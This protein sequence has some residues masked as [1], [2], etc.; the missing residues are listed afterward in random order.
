MKTCHLFSTII[1]SVVLNWA[2]LNAQKIDSMP[3]VCLNHVLI[4]LD[5]ATYQN[6]FNSS[7]LSDTV[8]NC[9]AHTVKTV[10][11]EW[12]GKYLFGEEGY[13]ELFSTKGGN[14]TPLGSFGF[15]FF[16]FRTG[17]I[18][19][20][21]DEWQ[22]QTTN[23]IWTDT[24]IY[25]DKGIKKSWFYSIGLAPEDSSKFLPVWLMENTPEHM[26]DAGFNDSELKE[27]ISWGTYSRKRREIESFPKL[28]KGITS[29]NITVGSDEFDFLKKTIT[30]FGLH[31]INK[32]FSNPYVCI[33]C[34]VSPEPIWRINTVT[35][36]LKEDVPYRKLGI[37]DNLVLEFEGKSAVFTF[38]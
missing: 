24:T 19:T 3:S 8:G 20:I 18:W 6:L 10:D 9:E 25:E 36:E 21:R 29:V 11:D 32:A 30:G 34:D 4:Y 38:K 37:S 15:G 2:S 26:K 35:F 28:L 7:F 27:E 12:S 23:I 33:T 1:F 22:K 16:T 17:D 14:D 13:L 5:S 31:Q